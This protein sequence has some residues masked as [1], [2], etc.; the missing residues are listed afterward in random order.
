MY[1]W[2]KHPT[3]RILKLKASVMGEDVASKRPV[4]KPKPTT[5]SAKSKHV[6]VVVG[7]S[8]QIHARV[9]DKYDDS[10]LQLKNRS[11]RLC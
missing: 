1:I 10:A 3:G 9:L 7:S 5:R 8:A 4:V 11:C 6:D 2:V